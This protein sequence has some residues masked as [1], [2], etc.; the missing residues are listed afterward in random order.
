MKNRFAKKLIL[1][2]LIPFLFLPTSCKKG[3]FDTVPDNINTIDKVFSNRANTERWFFSLYAG[4]QDI[5]DQPYGYQYAGTCDELEYANWGTGNAL[6]I[7]SGAV[8]SDN[9]PTRFE[10]YYQLI[11]NINIFLERV[12]ECKELLE[13]Q[14]GESIVKEYKGEARFLRAYYH[15]LLMKE[16]GP[17][18]IAP[19][20][21]GLPNDNFQIPRSSWDECVKF[22]LNEMRAS[23]ASLTS[24]HLTG[25]NTV[26]DYQVGRITIPIAA[27][28][29]AQILLAHASPLF[30]GNSE[31]ADW[32]NFDGKQLFNQTYDP[33]RWTA[34]AEA[35]KRAIDLNAAQGHKL[36]I[37]Q[38]AN[39]FLQGFNSTRDMFWDGWK[40]EGV[41]LRRATNVHSGWSQHC[42]PKNSL[43][44]NGWNG[45]GV[46]Q[47]LVDDFRMENGRGIKETPSYNETTFTNTATP[48]YS[49]GTNNM[50]VGREPRFYVDVTFSGA[51]IPV[52]PAAG[53]TYVT[54]YS[55]AASGK[56]ANARDYPKTGYTARKNIHPN[57]NL[58]T[59]SN[60]ARP[61]MLIRMAELYLSYAEALNESQP[62]HADVLK[63]LN[64][65]RTRGG[66]P[67]IPAD[68]GQAEMRK[69]IRLERR[70]ELC[71]ESGIRFWDVRRWKI[72][73]EMGSKQGGDFYG[74]NIDAGT[75][76]SDPAFYKRVVATTRVLWQRKF[77]F[78]PY[79]QNE[80][81]RNKQIVQLPGY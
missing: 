1:A 13:Q 27:A 57:T 79:R 26:D 76:L 2:L 72:P 25:S 61:A 68:L 81:D 42:A 38:N 6:T 44:G 78:L 59:G 20:V 48:Y 24:L 60:P 29:E 18:A 31:F 56:K 21:S 64:E 34:A 39:L 32:K 62:G 55:T 70:I 51:V 77:Y 33:T 3:Y 75:S 28:I 67:A 54:Y 12:D 36:F 65:V 43:S 17:A 37:K 58:S 49:A 5:W 46:L 41:W 22:V 71:Y 63:Y 30:N 80:M 8:T 73:D 4:I 15:W 7:N 47:E 16:V 40:E 66:I 69:Q 19:L 11:R 14:N 50:Y 23:E 52:V 45:I 74:M 35:M 53:Q 10:T 9:S